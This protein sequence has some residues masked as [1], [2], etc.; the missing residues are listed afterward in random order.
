MLCERENRKAVEEGD[1]ML[2]I[3]GVLGI[4]LLTLCTAG[5]GVGLVVGFIFSSSVSGK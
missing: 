3:I 2:W 5:A 4:V 1:D